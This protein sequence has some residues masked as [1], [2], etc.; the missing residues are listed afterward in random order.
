MLQIF[1]IVKQFSRKKNHEHFSELFS[2]LSEK[3]T[4]R[5]S[6]LWDF[7]IEAEK[8]RHVSLKLFSGFL[9][10]SVSNNSEKCLRMLL[11]FVFF[12][13]FE[14]CYFEKMLLWFFINF[15]KPGKIRWIFP[16]N[17][18]LKKNLLKPISLK[19]FPEQKSAEIK[20]FRVA[21]VKKS[22]Q[23]QIRGVFHFSIVSDFSH[24]KTNFQKTKTETLF[25]ICFLFFKK[26]KS[27][28]FFQFFGISKSRPKN[29]CCQLW[30]FQPPIMGIRSFM[31][32]V[33]YK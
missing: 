13:F 24:S 31:H 14:F 28:F 20:F 18:C 4:E 21:S 8:W 23:K 25:Q 32:Y 27:E 10:F 17:L 15:E 26:K 16:G 22:N 29:G 7:K 3:K 2:N 1:L 12:G 19:Q 30:K 11:C 9:G 33:L 6:L 5:F